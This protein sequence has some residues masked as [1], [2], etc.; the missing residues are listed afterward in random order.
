MSYRICVGLIAL[1]VFL[2][3][4][5]QAFASNSGV[6]IFKH[7][8]PETTAF[9]LTKIIT[10]ITNIDYQLQAVPFQLSA[11]DDQTEECLRAG[12]CKD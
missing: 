3:N 6:A 1:P 7:P 4:A 8:I 2:W 9:S 5:G 12:N 11:R 10:N